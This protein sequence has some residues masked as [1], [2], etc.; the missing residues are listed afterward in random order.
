MVEGK[1]LPYGGLSR[2]CIT[3]ARSLTDDD[4]VAITLQPEPPPGAP[5]GA[6][7]SFSHFGER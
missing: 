4:E 5:G 3:F 6:A 7:S 2:P 1:Q